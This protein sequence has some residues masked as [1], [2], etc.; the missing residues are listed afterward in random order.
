MD[1]RGIQGA[2]RY[3]AVNRYIALKARYRDVPVSGVLELTPY[4]N[5]DCKMCYVHLN[6]DQI[7]KDNRLLEVKEWK[8]IIKQ[9]V[10]AGMIFTT[11]TGGECLTY[12]GFKEIYSYLVSLGIQ[13]DILT[14]GRLLTEEMIE[15]FSQNPP[16]VMQISLYGSNEEAYERVTG[17][18]A[19]RQVMD[20]IQRAKKAR[21]NLSIAVTPNRYMQ[22]DVAEL[23]GLIH[24]LKIPYAIGDAT[25]PARSDTQRHVS[26]YVADIDTYLELLRVNGEF[27]KKFPFA[28]DQ[29][30]VPCYMP[31]AV[32][33]LRG[34]PCGGGHSSFHVN[35]KGEICP[36]IA[37]AE[38]VHYSALDKGFEA[39][40]EKVREKMKE[41]EQPKACRKCEMQAV[42]QACPGER[43]KGN[44]NGDAN[45]IICARI[46]ARFAQMQ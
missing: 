16:G 24:E 18:R 27:M 38:S 33:E 41:Y 44:P 25:L 9:A 10:D 42:C 40:W 34:L 12:P 19:F 31:P 46:R 20:G 39:A 2:R 3:R 35:W 37:F 4:C 6:A 43:S 23:I 13:P 21:L 22:K 17:H 30:M 11:L 45:E 8:E 15:F 36:C 32:K 7:G 29:A 26:E 1:E 14:N 28:E 5:L